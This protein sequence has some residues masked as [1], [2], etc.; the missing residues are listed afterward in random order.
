MNAFC[1]SIVDTILD[2]NCEKHYSISNIDEKIELC[3]EM[4]ELE[5]Y[6]KIQLDKK[7]QKIFKKYNE[8]WDKLHCELS[9]DTLAAGMKLAEGRR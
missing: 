4:K 6:I 3:I 7:H 8:A 2:P 1:S 9:V 5:D